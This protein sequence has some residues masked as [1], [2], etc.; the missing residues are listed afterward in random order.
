VRLFRRK[1]DDEPVDMNARSPQLGVKYKDLMVLDQLVKN[2]ADLSASRHVIYYSY[3]P[4]REVG[5]AMAAEAEAAGWAAEVRE[6]LPKFPDQWGVICQRH[7]VTSPDFVREAVRVSPI[8]T[9][10]NTTAGRPARRATSVGRAAS[11]LAV[12]VER[13]FAPA[14]V[15]VLR[16]LGVIRRSRQPSPRPLRTLNEDRSVQVEALG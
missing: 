13:P 9:G 6:P 2:G 7:A 10:R 16:L 5:E 15:N 12:V 4:V 8:D 1:R 14:F 11:R 3:A